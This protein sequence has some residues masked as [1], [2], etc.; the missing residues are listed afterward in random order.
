MKVEKDI[1]DAASL[2]SGVET[3]QSGLTNFE[4]T[5][6]QMKSIFEDFEGRLNKLEGEMLPMKDISAKLTLARGNIT[7]AI[8][9]V[10]QTCTRSIGLSRT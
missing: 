5:T 7:S 1:L 3:L 9:K 8:V 4:V 6:G 2:A 10:L